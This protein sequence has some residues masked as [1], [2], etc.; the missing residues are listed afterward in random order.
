MP[1]CL[2]RLDVAFLV[3]ALA[4]TACGGQSFQNGADGT[5]AGA[6]SAG[7][8]SAGTSNA[9]GSSGGNG[10]G[11]GAGQ[12][13]STT[14]GKSQ[15]GSHSGGA[16]SSGAAAG[17]VG[18][19][20]SSQCDAFLDEH[21]STIT[22]RLTNDTMAPIY[23]GQQMQACGEPDLFDVT[24]AAGAALVSPGFCTTTCEQIMHNAVMG[25]PPIAC[26]AGS[27]ITLQPGESALRQWNGVFMVEAELPTACLPN[28]EALSMCE[29]VASAKPGA[30][31]FSARAG[32][33][34]QCSSFVGGVCQ[35]CMPDSSGGCSTRGGLIG[36]TI[37]SAETKVMLDGSYGVGGAGGGGMTRPVEIVFK[38]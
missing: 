6:A 1:R 18:T 31:T 11:A 32:T 2:L 15:G 14:G 12:G 25:C 26:I 9:G 35:A 23:L 13:G 4:A 20:G 17:G 3:S 36:G 28:P 19:G 7:A 21:S 27:A 24:D 8:A 34:L 33:Q 29:R 30:F 22:V 10:N 5:N 37:L 16:G 38:N